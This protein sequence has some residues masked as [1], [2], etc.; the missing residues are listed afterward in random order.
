M[1]CLRSF[2]FSIANQSNYGAAQ[3]FL[4][5][6]IG[7]QHF[8]TLDTS[9][10]TGSSTYVI[11]G[12]KNINIFKIELTGDFNSSPQ[13]SPFQC[14]VQNWSLVFNVIGQNSTSVGSVFL[15]TNSFGMFDQPTNAAFKLSKFQPSIT[16]ETPIQSAKEIILQSFFVDGIANHTT[17]SAQIGYIINFTVFYKYEGE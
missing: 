13:F 2:N 12:F 5:W 9:S 7:T 11:Q 3:G 8:W 1:D 6:Q 16:F 4:Y 15:G 14:I 10:I 17:T